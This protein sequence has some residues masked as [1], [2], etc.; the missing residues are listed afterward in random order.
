MRVFVTGATGWIGSAT[1]DELLR[2][3]HRV[4]GLARSEDSASSLERKGALVLRGDLDDLETLRRGAAD[5]DA[6]I[7]LGNKHDWAN[8]AESDRTERV[9]VQTLAGALVNSYRPFLVA[10]AFAGVVQGRP[11][12]ETD[13]SPAFGPDSMRG[14]GENLALEYVDRGVRTIITRFAPSVHGVGDRGFVNFLVAAARRHGVSA[15]VG[16]GAEA[17][18]AVHRLDTAQL[19]RLG[20]EQAPAGARLHAVAEETIPTRTI[21]EAIGDFLGLPVVAIA[22]EAASAHF[23]VVGRFFGSTMTASSERTRALLGWMPVGPTLV[24]D[25]AAGAYADA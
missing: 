20:L 5:A 13:P 11:A 21:A 8:R 7:H 10:S 22:P 23:G 12:L 6:V 18:S 3:G 17:W 24:E 19:M 1:V 25:I 2:G 14:G 9:A 15:Y 4:V 16:D